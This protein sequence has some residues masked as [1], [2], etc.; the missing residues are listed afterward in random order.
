[1]YE[2]V[3]DDLRWPKM[4]WDLCGIYLRFIWHHSLISS[5]QAE[6]LA[7]SRLCYWRLTCEVLSPARPS[8]RE[9]LPDL[10]R[11]SLVSAFSALGPGNSFLPPWWP[12]GWQEPSGTCAQ[13]AAGRWSWSATWNMLKHAETGS[14]GRHFESENSWGLRRGV[15]SLSASLPGGFWNTHHSALTI[16]MNTCTRVTTWP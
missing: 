3:Q 12:W 5:L 8:Q 16:W 14:N 9:P 2:L 13:V 4:I 7:T 1:M 6:H 15:L 11:F 10:P